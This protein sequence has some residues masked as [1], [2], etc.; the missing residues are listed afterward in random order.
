[1]EEDVTKTENNNNNIIKEQVPCNWMSEIFS[2][3]TAGS[4][5]Q[6]AKTEISSQ[7]SGSENLDV[8]WTG[9]PASAANCILQV[10]R[11]PL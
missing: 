9:V 2:E 11:K 4:L 10:T 5:P 6:Q 7:E 8:L 3:F 1:M